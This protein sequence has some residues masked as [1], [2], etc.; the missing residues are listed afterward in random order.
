ML[1]FVGPSFLPLLHI[2]WRLLCINGTMGNI[3]TMSANVTC[4]DCDVALTLNEQPMVA[5]KAI[6]LQI[7]LRIPAHLRSGRGSLVHSRG[8]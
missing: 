8:G 5:M 1:S 3:Q 7:A 2:E 6:G 4:Q